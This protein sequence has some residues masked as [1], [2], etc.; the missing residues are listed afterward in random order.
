MTVQESSLQARPAPRR[1]AVLLR[2]LGS[3]RPAFWLSAL[4][5]LTGLGLVF[6][7]VGRTTPITTTDRLWHDIGASLIILAVAAP[8]PIWRRIER[9]QYEIGRAHV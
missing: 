6:V 8:L 5:A 9:E 7:G 3:R 4:G 1:A 2:F